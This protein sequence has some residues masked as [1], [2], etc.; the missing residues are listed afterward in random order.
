[1]YYTHTHLNPD[2]AHEI[3]VEI[4]WDEVDPNLEKVV[5]EARS[6]G[7]TLSIVVGTPTHGDAFVDRIEIE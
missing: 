2:Q 7:K 6:Q 1:M 5:E 4:Y 3:L